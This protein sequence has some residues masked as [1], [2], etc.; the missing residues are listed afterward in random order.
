M[1]AANVELIYAR[2]RVGLK[3]RVCVGEGHGSSQN[4]PAG[5]LLTDGEVSKKQE[6]GRAKD[7]TVKR[8]EDH[9]PS[10]IS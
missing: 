5:K 1:T 4:Q 6:D 9:H 2:S 8:G 3:A 10:C 7:R